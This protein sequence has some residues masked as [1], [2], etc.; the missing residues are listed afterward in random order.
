[1]TAVLARF[2]GNS[3]TVTKAGAGAGTLTSNPAGIS[4]SGA[5]SAPFAAVPVA[6]TATPAAG[7]IFTGWSGGGC[8]GTGTCQV[9]MSSDQSVTASF[10]LVA[11][12]LVVAKSGS[13]TGTVISNP[14]AINCGS[15]CGHAFDHG[16][17]IT[18]TATAS[19]GS[20][21]SGWSGDCSGKRTCALTMD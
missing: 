12:A 6:L 9:Q 20:Q 1:S 8:S 18:L 16:S 5:C 4:C 14:P 13:G 21:F 10:G 19:Q 11:K 2:L 15:A 3:L 17:E 7:S